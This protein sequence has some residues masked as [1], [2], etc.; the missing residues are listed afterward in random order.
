MRLLL[1]KVASASVEVEGDTVGS[2]G[3]GYLIFVGVMMGDTQADAHLLAEKISKLRLFPSADGR[4]NDQ[5][6][7]DVHGEVLVISQFTLAGR[8]EKG[9]RPDYTSAE[10]PEQAQKL[11]LYFMDQLRAL[12]TKKVEH[13]C[14]GAEMQV[15]LT[16]TGP[17]TLMLDSHSLL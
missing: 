2:I 5:S 14:F 8:T 15:H 1:Q 16:N 11:Y 3:S 7:L 12:G 4:I 17:V 6:L 13:G 9:N 10:K